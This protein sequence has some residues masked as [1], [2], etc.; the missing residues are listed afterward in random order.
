MDKLDRCYL[1]LALKAQ[2]QCRATLATLAAVK[3]PQPVAFVRQANIAHGPQQVNNAAAAEASRAGIGLTRE[4][5]NGPA[6]RLAER[7]GA[8]SLRLR[9]RYAVPNPNAAG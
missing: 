4:H 3:N 7:N 6:A 1:R 9:A 2:S 5:H 8:M